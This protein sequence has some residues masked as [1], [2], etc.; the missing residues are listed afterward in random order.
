MVLDELAIW[1]NDAWLVPFF[2][3]CINNVNFTQDVVFE[4]TDVSHSSRRQEIFVVSIGGFGLGFCKP[5]GGFDLGKM[6]V[7]LLPPCA[8]RL[9]AAPNKSE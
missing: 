2:C 4:S 6:T 7:D 8:E 5:G 9:I 3:R 1:S